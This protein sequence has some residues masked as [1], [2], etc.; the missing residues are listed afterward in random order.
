LSVVPGSVE[1]A[2]LWSV[3]DPGCWKPCDH[4]R[5]GRL[6]RA[7]QWTRA[8]GLGRLLDSNKSSR[9]WRHYNYCGHATV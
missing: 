4:A 2:I 8:D 5:S 7:C 1:P 9:C 3:T 6:A